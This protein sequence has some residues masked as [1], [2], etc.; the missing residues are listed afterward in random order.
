MER[1]YAGDVEF[2]QVLAAYRGELL[3]HCYRML[4]SVHDAE[5]ALQESMVRAWR[6]LD[7]FDG[8]GSMRPWLYRIATNRC[9]TMLDKRARRE[10]PADLSPGAPL[11]EVAWLTPYPSAALDPA[12]T[13]EQREGVELAFVAAQHLS[14]TQRAVLVLRDVL[15]FSAAEVAGQLGTT[16][17]A[18]NSGLQRARKVVASHNPPLRPASDATIKDLADRYAAAW[19][20]GDVDAIV[21]LLA[22][23]ATYSMPPL[24]QWY[25]GTAAIRAWLLS[26][27]LN[28]H[29][30][31]QPAQAN[32][33]LAHGTYWWQDGAWDWISLDVLRFA[34]SHIV[35]VVS[36]LDADPATFGLPTRGTWPPP[37]T[38]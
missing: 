8:R 14:P 30:R 5:D 32:G 26:E 33:Q 6:S 31:F 4:G 17:A 10:L 9:L 24:P 38:P 37:P 25:R 19:E 1:I 34:G 29:W 28:N 11:A 35:E 21:A 13:A 3:A 2:E 23:D 16:V 20:A 27:P 36:F 22:E 7:S 18:V 15:E 12:A